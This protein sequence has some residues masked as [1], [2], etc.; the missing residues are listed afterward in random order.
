VRATKAW[1][2]IAILILALAGLGWWLAARASSLSTTLAHAN[3]QK[4]LLLHVGTEPSTLDPQLVEI[5]FIGT[6]RI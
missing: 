1:A 6:V 3:A 4:I 5:R 2:T